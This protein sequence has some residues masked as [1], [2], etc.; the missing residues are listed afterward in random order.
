MLIVRSRTLRHLSFKDTLS[1]M[2]PTMTVTRVRHSSAFSES[3]TEVKRESSCSPADMPARRPS[4]NLIRA[5]W[6]E[7]LCAHEHLSVGMSVVHT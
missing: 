5:E 6:W 2:V 3:L 4:P 7:S 1:V